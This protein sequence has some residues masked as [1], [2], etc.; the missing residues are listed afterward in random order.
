MLWNV[1]VVAGDRQTPLGETRPRG[2][3]LLAV[4]NPL[5][6][7][8]RGPGGDRCEVGT[9]RWFREE[10]AT[11]NVHTHERLNEVELLLIGSVCRDRWR[12]QAH[13]GWWKFARRGHMKPCFLAV[14]CTQ[15]T[16]GKTSSAQRRR[17]IEHCVAGIELL[18]L[19]DPCGFKAF[20]LLLLGQVMKHRHIV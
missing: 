9:R 10:L 4:E 20:G 14:V 11:E 13:R 2:P 5:V 8:E 15:V 6:A 12:D 19:P 1:G 16:V 18:L 7:I 3:H 17:P